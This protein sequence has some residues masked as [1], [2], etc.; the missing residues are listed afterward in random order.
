M[1]VT[2]G[3]ASCSIISS[4][5][6]TPYRC[7][8]HRH[9]L[10]ISDLNV[11]LDQLETCKYVRRL[12]AMVLTAN[13]QRTADHSAGKSSAKKGLIRKKPQTV[14]KQFKKNI[15]A[16]LKDFEE[17]ICIVIEQSQDPDPDDALYSVIDTSG[18]DIFIRLS[19]CRRRLC[20]Q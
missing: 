16:Q 7:S 8:T 12:Y 6:F 13:K 9:A 19:N 11:R 20:F 1:G 17:A 14:Q 5:N 4:L 15:P 10:V 3:W 18:E 2:F